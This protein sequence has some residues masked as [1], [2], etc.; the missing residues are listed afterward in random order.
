VGINV[1]FFKQTTVRPAHDLKS[2]PD[3]T[4]RLLGAAPSSLL[5]TRSSRGRPENDLVREN[6]WHTWAMGRGD[7]PKKEKKK[8]KKK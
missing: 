8:P 5:C 3:G 2:R 4:G 1:E 7:K 6:W